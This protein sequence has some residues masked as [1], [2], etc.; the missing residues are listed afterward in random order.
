MA[1]TIDFMASSFF[2]LPSAISV[3]YPSLVSQTAGIVPLL[4][5]FSAKVQ[6]RARSK[7]LPKFSIPI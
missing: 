1:E 5:E 4:V 7:K 2:L 3:N 6:V